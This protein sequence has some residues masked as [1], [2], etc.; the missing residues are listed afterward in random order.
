M[1]AHSRRRKQKSNKARV[2]DHIFHHEDKS[3]VIR[4][5]DRETA[6]VYFDKLYLSDIQE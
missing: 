3:I 6:Q 2:T 1:T 4:A 5:T